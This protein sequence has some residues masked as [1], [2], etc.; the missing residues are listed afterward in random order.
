MFKGEEIVNEYARTGLRDDVER[1]VN[2]LIS[3]RQK[4]I[5]V[6]IVTIF[7][8]YVS[9]A[10]WIGFTVNNVKKDTF[11]AND[12]KREL[13]ARVDSLERVKIREE[14]DAIAYAKATDSLKRVKL[15][16]INDNYR[17]SIEEWKRNRK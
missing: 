11:N 12:F 15:F 14:R 17:K 3:V 10:V 2:K 13:T 6:G 7:I 8:I 5:V 16:E 9:L 4:W 1:T